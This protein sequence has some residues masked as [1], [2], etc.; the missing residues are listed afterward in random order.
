MKMKTLHIVI[1]I[2]AC[3][4]ST[5][6][7]LI[8]SHHIID[9]NQNIWYILGFGSSVAIAGLVGTIAIFSPKKSAILA[10]AVVGV[11]VLQLVVNLSGVKL[12]HY[13]I[14][15]TRP[16]ELAGSIEFGFLTS[17][18]MP[19]VFFASIFCAVTWP[20]VVLRNRLLKRLK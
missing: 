8:Q 13:P 15:I 16:E 9:I 11:V 2:L 7:V 18:V 17:P 5:S 6:F 20:I 12:W 10:C 14:I 1:I 3:F 19:F 4:V